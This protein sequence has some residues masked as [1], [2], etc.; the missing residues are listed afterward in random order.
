MLFRSYIGSYLPA[1]ERLHVVEVNVRPVLKIHMYAI[2]CRVKRNGKACNKNTT[3]SRATS[4]E[5][6]YTQAL[7]RASEMANAPIA[8]ATRILY[9]CKEAVLQKRNTF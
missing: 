9:L 5:W 7:A 8:A 4:H 6:I 3:W 1:G 2:Q